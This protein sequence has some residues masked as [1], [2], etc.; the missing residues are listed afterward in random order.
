MSNYSKQV[1]KNISYIKQYIT[2]Y[3]TP[4]YN[5]NHIFLLIRQSF[6]FIVFDG[7]TLSCTKAYLCDDDKLHA[8]LKD[9]TLFVKPIILHFPSIPTCAH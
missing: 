1:A 3:A 5:C 2:H 8:S 6:S 9:F 7:H 4:S